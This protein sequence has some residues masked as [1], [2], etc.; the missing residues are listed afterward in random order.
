MVTYV[1]C[2]KVLSQKKSKRFSNIFEKTVRN[3]MNPVWYQGYYVQKGD[4]SDN[5]R[6][7]S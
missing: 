3:I 5:N 1:A 4:P 2:G 7:L 6:Y